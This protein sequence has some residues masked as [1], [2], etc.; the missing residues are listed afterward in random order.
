MSK[1]SHFLHDR[2]NVG[3]GDNKAASMASFY[4]NRPTGPTV[5]FSS[6][7]IP[8]VPSSPFGT[9]GVP[10]AM[11]PGVGAG[12]LTP[13]P[14]T[15][16]VP[17]FLGSLGSAFGNMSMA[18]KLALAG[19]IMQGVGGVAGGIAK[20]KELGFEKQQYQT[21]LNAMNQFRGQMQAPQNFAPGSA[22]QGVP[23]GP[24]GSQAPPQTSPG[25]A[26][27][28]RWAALLAARGIGG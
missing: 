16:G 22:F 7:G 6:P 21:R 3:T 4:S 5:P 23:I 10:G 13:P 26:L 12:G 1:L 18:D 19:L 14:S 9:P 25:S 2:W 24:P 17:G 28:Q 20:G 27:S 8:S 11:P 15:P